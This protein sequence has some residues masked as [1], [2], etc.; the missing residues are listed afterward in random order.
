MKRIL[1]T[2]YAILASVLASAAN[3]TIDGVKYYTRTDGTAYVNGYT[4]DMPSDL[5]IPS[6]ITYDGSEY[7]VTSI[8]YEAFYGCTGLTAVTIPSS[9]TYIGSSAFSGCVGLTLLTLEEG[10]TTLSFDD[11]SS[12]DGAFNDCPIETI[13][14]GRNFSHKSSYSSSYSPF[15]NKNSLKTLT[16]GDKVTSIGYEAF[17]GCTGLTSLTLED[18]ETTLSF[19]T[20]SNS[21]GGAFNSCPIETLYLGRNISYKSSPFKNISSLKTLTISNKVTSIGNYTFHGCA[22]LTVVNIPNSVTAIGSSAFSG[23]AGLTTVTIPNSVT[24]IESSVFSG[25]AGLT[26][27]TIPNSV[28][29]IGSSAFSGCAGLTLLTL[30]DGETTLSF[31]DS[32]SSDGAFNDCPIETLYLGRNISYYYSPFENKSSLN[33]LTISDKVTSIGNYAFQ[34]CT[35]LTAVTIPN[36]VTSIGEFAFD[37]CT[38]LTSVTVPNSVTSIGNYAFKSC[39]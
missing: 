28:T 32:S 22:G 19:D 20:S 18:G 33:T 10:E 2:L 36:S 8:R 12:S 7:S 38:G 11:S 1:L 17:Y 35:G 25:C 27:V 21:G 26:T 14:L 39:I 34:G 6:V 23:C 13:Y 15:K 5:E 29:A 16:I 31:D 24:A 4:A 30:E 37:G 9:V 3:V